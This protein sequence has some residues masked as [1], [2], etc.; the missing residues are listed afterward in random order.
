M[1]PAFANQI[2]TAVCRDKAGRLTEMQFD[3]AHKYLESK[4]AVSQQGIQTA[5]APV[6]EQ[7]ASVVIT[8]ESIPA[9]IDCLRK[10]L[11]EDFNN[12]VELLEAAE[13]NG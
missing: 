8:A 3:F 9:L 7:V 5:S 11:G 6:I 13:E 4:P 2:G 12:I 1:R 10:S